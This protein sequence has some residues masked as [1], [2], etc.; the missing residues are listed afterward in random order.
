M[1]NIDWA[2]VLFWGL[3]IWLSLKAFEGYLKAKNAQ[4]ERELGDLQKKVRETIIKVNVEKHGDVFYLFEQDTDRFIAQG[5]NADEIK[6]VLLKRF[7]DKTVFAD[8]KVLET[9]GLTL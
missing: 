9:V 7:P 4:L 6:E 2:S 5:K 3:I 1:E 8:K